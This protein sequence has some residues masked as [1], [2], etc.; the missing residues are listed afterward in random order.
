MKRSTK[1]I[2]LLLSLLFVALV[3]AAGWYYAALSSAYEG[4]VEVEPPPSIDKQVEGGAYNILLVGT[5]KGKRLT[6]TVMLARVDLD[7]STVSLLSLLRDTRVRMGGSYDKLNA[8]NVYRGIDGLVACVKELTGAPVHYYAVVSLDAFTKVIDYFGGVQ[9]DVPEDMRYRDPYQN[10]NIDLKAGPQLLDG[11][12]SMQLVRFRRYSEGD[13]QRTRVQQQFVKAFIEQH[14]VTEN[15]LKIPELFRQLEDDLTT[16]ITLGDVLAKMPALRLFEAE[17]AVR[18]HELP[19]AG[20]YVGGISYF[21]HD[22][23]AT[24]ALCQE[25]FG[26]SGEPAERLYTDYSLVVPE[27]KPVAAPAEQPEPSEPEET[28]ENPAV[29][30]VTETATETTEAPS[31]HPAEPAEPEREVYVTLE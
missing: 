14:A 27:P 25:H 22:P 4:V 8:V 26:G 1:A 16:S 17:D 18:I 7:Q 11:D 15:L 23:A 20:K 28:G 2:L 29:E 6:D 21:V 3:F 12:K 30:T 9:F 13:I 10:L 31:D 5:D 19:G 24:W